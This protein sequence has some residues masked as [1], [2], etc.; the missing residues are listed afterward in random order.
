MYAIVEISGKQYKVEKD[1]FIY[2]DKLDEKV[3][4]KIDFKNVLFIENKGKISLGKPLISG[5]KV[6]GEILAHLKDDKKIVFK[7]KRRK[8]YKTK[9]GH[10]QLLSKVL[11]KSI[12]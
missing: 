3:G 11:I 1:K 9:N 7:K 8:G 10:R 6:V 4:K 5:S 2:T 12:K